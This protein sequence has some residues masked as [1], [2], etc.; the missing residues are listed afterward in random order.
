MVIKF[1]VSCSFDQ[2]V[3]RF[4]PKLSRWW[5]FI[6]RPHRKWAT[7]KAG[8]FPSDGL[9]RYQYQDRGSPALCAHRKQLNWNKLRLHV[10]VWVRLDPIS[11]LGKGDDYGV[12]SLNKTQITFNLNALTA[13]ASKRAAGMIPSILRFLHFVVSW[14]RGQRKSDQHSVHDSSLPLPYKLLDFFGHTPCLG[15]ES[16]SGADYHLCGIV[17]SRILTMC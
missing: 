3:N 5:A 17:D 1:G 9:R 2:F 12:H 8:W 15:E 4:I 14:A 10:T 16:D 6:K 7:Q 13:R 11:S